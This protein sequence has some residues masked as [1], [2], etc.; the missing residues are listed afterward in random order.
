M[1][2]EP[3]STESTA[4]YHFGDGQPD[5]NRLLPSTRDDTEQPA[6]LGQFDSRLTTEEHRVRIG[7]QRVNLACE[8]T[9]ERR[10]AGTVGAQDGQVLALAHDELVHVKNRASVAHDARIANAYELLG[11]RGHGHAPLWR[12]DARM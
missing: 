7:P 12:L 11:E 1:R 8:Q 5:T 4:Q 9:D 10:L 2:R 6:R 3:E